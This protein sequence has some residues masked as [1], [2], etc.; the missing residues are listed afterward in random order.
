MSS[1][2]RS[3]ALCFSI[4]TWPESYLLQTIV[5]PAAAAEPTPVPEATLELAPSADAAQVCHVS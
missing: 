4:A 3:Q 5:T 2:L 1:L